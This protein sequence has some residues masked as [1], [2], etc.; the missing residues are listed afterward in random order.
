[1]TLQRHITLPSQITLQRH[2]ITKTRN[3]TR[4]ITLQRHMA[5]QITLQRQHYKDTHNNTKTKARIQTTFS[6]GSLCC[7]YPPLSGE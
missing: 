1:M 5:L 6:S 7:Q 3:I 4:H 2:S